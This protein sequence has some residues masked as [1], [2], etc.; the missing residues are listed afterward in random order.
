MNDYLEGTDAAS[1]QS[2]LPGNVSRLLDYSGKE[3]IFPLR[4]KYDIA[5]LSSA[6]LLGPDRFIAHLFQSINYLDVH[7]ALVSQLVGFDKSYDDIDTDSVERNIQISK[8]IDCSCSLPMSKL[9]RLNASQLIGNFSRIQNVAAGQDE[10]SVIFYHSSLIIQPRYQSVFHACRFQFNAVLDY[11]ELH[12]SRIKEANIT[13]P[14]PNGC[15]QEQL[16]LTFKYVIAFCRQEPLIAWMDPGSETNNR[17]LRLLKLCIELEAK[18]EGIEMLALLGAEFDREK[19][20]SENIPH[21]LKIGLPDRIS[22]G[23]YDTN[24][25]EAIANFVSQFSGN[26]FYIFVL[27]PFCTDDFSIIRLG[28]VRTSGFENDLPSTHSGSVGVLY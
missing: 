15:E 2:T 3:L 7:L 28:N 4:E 5:D 21:I 1:Y 18:Q 11:L 16:A 19:K 26:Y 13:D 17:S 10:Q 9:L 22:L 27:L 24:V 25:A 14:R 20:D 8:W 23:I 12:Q 6:I